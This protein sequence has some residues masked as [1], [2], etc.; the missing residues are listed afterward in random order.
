[1]V[2]VGEM[3]CVGK[4]RTLVLHSHPEHQTTTTAHTNPS[5]SALAALYTSAPQNAYTS[6]PPSLRRQTIISLTLMTSKI[7]STPRSRRTFPTFSE[8]SSDSMDTRETF[9]AQRRRP[10]VFEQVADTIDS[11]ERLLNCSNARETASCI[12][13]DELC[14]Q[15]LVSNITAFYKT[16]TVIEAHSHYALKETVE[17]RLGKHWLFINVAWCMHLFAYELELTLPDFSFQ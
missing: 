2:C 1:M 12:L 3:A 15:N 13:H 5:T 14:R 6:D 4:I 16:A 9:R 7:T 8:Q 10:A 17:R 11:Q